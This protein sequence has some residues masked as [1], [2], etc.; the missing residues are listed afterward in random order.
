M[1]G[2]SVALANQSSY[3]SGIILILGLGIIATYTGYVMG[4]FKLKYVRGI[5]DERFIID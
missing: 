5:L 4:Q 1:R 3:C 2:S